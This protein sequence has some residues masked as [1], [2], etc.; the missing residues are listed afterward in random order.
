M[1]V[2]ENLVFEMRESVIPIRSKSMSS[3]VRS[4][5]SWSKLFDGEQTF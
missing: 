1:F 5:W 4:A 2:E 3:S